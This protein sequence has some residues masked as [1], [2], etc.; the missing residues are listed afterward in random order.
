MGEPQLGLLL[1]QPDEPRDREAVLRS[2]VR[3]QLPASCVQHEDE[4]DLHR[5][6]ARGDAKL[7]SPRH[8]DS[9]EGLGHNTNYVKRTAKHL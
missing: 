8:F 3:L 9:I 5:G 7:R 4:Q 6:G 1:P 2:D